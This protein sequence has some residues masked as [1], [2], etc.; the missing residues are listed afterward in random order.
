[1]WAVDC[2]G[3]GLRQDRRLGSNKAGQGIDAAILRQLHA[4][5]TTRQ[6]WNPHIATHGTTTAPT[7]STAA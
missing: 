5:V 2:G 7:I 3:S 4:V 6:P 1:M